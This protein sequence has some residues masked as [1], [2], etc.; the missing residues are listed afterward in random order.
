MQS[1]MNWW[2]DRRG[3]KLWVSRSS[4]PSKDRRGKKAKLEWEYMLYC[5]C[6]VQ[7][8]MCKCMQLATKLEEEVGGAQ[9]YCSGTLNDKARHASAMV[10]VPSTW[11][12]WRV[13]M[14]HG[15]W[16]YSFLFVTVVCL[17]VMFGLQNSKVVGVRGDKDKGHRGI[18]P[19]ITS[20]IHT[21]PCQ[22]IYYVKYFGF[23]QLL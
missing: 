20:Q 1:K 15:W 13:T 12:C 14:D 18:G 22:R 11:G 10:H 17:F 19:H 21:A 3:K 4:F 5:R 6:N 7:C 9:E 23:Y 16:S 8:A 2:R